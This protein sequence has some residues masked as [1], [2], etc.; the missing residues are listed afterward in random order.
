MAT[1]TAVRQENEVIDLDVL[2]GDARRRIGE[3]MEVRQR[4]SLDALTDEDAQRELANVESELAATEGELQRVD[5]ARTES[6]RRVQ[7]AEREAE[8]KRQAA[9]ERR[10]AKLKPEVLKAEQAVDAAFAAAG[11]A[12][13]S[14]LGV[15]GELLQAAGGR[16][17][18]GNDLTPSRLEGSL[19]H[20][21]A[22]AGVPPR[23]LDLGP[24]RTSGPLA[25]EAK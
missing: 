20:H 19:H 4:L 2:E 7:E 10:V 13:A 25:P 22:A 21:F 6:G 23:L 17:Q 9:A 5:L 18:A 3:L 11:G 12:V 15:Q 16:G 8:A 24:T 1:A 14:F